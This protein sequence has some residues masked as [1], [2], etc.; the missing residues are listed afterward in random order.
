MLAIKSIQ[1]L[2]TGAVLLHLQ[3]LNREGPFISPGQIQPYRGGSFPSLAGPVSGIRRCFFL[4][5]FSAVMLSGGFFSLLLSDFSSARSVLWGEKNVLLYALCICCIM[6]N[7]ML[8]GG[9][10]EIFF[11][12]LCRN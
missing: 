8:R 10:E 7:A 5:D 12:F 4:V 2:S 11:L 1:R 6:Y 3:L 9:E